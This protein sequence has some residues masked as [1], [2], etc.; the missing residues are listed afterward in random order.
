M[1]VGEMPKIWLFEP[2]W[3]LAELTFSKEM[4]GNPSLN[5][6]VSGES[7]SL[8]FPAAREKLLLF[9]WI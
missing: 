8:V 6:S 3:L 1:L 7:F 4:F 9:S 5:I 2:T